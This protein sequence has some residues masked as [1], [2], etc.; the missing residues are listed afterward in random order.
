MSEDVY[1]IFV[2]IY[3]YIDMFM[4]AAIT[5]RAKFAEE[6][7]RGTRFLSIAERQRRQS[8]EPLGGAPL[9]GACHRKRTSHCQIVLNVW[10]YN[11]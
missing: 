3:R 9:A 1:E 10:D 11:I 4:T 2:H 8:I 5:Q 6:D 7:N